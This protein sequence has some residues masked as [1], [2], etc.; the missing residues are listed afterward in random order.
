MNRKLEA[1]R[2]LIHLKTLIITILPLCNVAMN[3]ASNQKWVFKDED[4]KLRFFNM[5]Y[6][7]FSMNKNKCMEMLF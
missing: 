1:K 4:G 7:L 5:L 3:I 6:Q 2:S